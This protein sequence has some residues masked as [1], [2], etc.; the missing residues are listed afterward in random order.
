MYPDDYPAC[1]MCGA[2]LGP[3]LGSLGP[4]E[5]FVAVKDEPNHWADEC[6]DPECAFHRRAV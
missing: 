2:T 1:I 5:P 4:P 3:S 6:R